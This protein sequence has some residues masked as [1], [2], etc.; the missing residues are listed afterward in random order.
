MHSHS[1][2]YLEMHPPLQG[3]R[4]FRLRL[5]RE[6][7]NADEIFSFGETDE[8]IYIGRAPV[9]SITGS[10]GVH[11]SGRNAGYTMPQGSVKSTGHPL[12]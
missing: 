1:S 12:H 7:T 8:S 4:N 2:N 10:R 11:F 6:G 5:K 9:Q 3:R